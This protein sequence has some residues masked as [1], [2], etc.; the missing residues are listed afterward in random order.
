MAVLVVSR[1]WGIGA[2]TCLPAPPLKVSGRI[3]GRATLNAREG[4]GAAR[5]I[6]IKLLDANQTVK[7]AIR[8]D[9]SGTF[10]FPKLPEGRYT[11]VVKGYALD[12][13]E[14]I[15]AA[16][17][18]LRR[19]TIVITLPFE[20]EPTCTGGISKPHENNSSVVRGNGLPH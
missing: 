15:G 10:S 17:A 9:G 19:E 14:V 5:R 16:A 11:V 6:S 12:E 1:P 4:E 20:P 2:T 13:I 3:C 18:C 8:T 7:A